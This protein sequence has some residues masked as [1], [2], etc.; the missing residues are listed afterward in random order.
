V[1]DDLGGVYAHFGENLQKVFG[2]NA[3]NKLLDG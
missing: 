3:L 1:V 2:D